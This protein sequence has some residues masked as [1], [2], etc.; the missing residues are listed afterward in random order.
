[1]KTQAILEWAGDLVQGNIHHHYCHTFPPII[2]W[3]NVSHIPKSHCFTPITRLQ[4]QQRFWGSIGHGGQLP[5]RQH[6][7]L[8]HQDWRD[9]L[10]LPRRWIREQSSTLSMIHQADDHPGD[11]TPPTPRPTSGPTKP[12][13]QPTTS[14]GP[15]PTDPTQV[16]FYFFVL[17][18][19]PTPFVIGSLWLWTFWWTGCFGFPYSFLNPFRKGARQ[20]LLS[21]FFC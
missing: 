6:Q 4:F 11:T 2:H 20:K 13:N 9:R 16:I 21:G 8:Q 1:M 3:Q 12:T 14:H 18:S 19:S 10:N 7:V 15:G 5:E 17:I